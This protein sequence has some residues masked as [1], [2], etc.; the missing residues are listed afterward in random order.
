MLAGID[1]NV[2]VG[3]IKYQVSVLAHQ[4]ERLEPDAAADGGASASGAAGVDSSTVGVSARATQSRTVVGQSKKDREFRIGFGAGGRF[5]IADWLRIYFG[6]VEGTGKYGRSGEHQVSRTAMS[7]RRYN[8]ETQ[9]D[10][11][12]YVMVYELQVRPKPDPNGLAEIWLIG[13]NR[14]LA[15]DIAVP[16]P[17]VPVR[18]PSAA[19][20]QEAGTAERLGV[21][22]GDEALRPHWPDGAAGEDF[23]DFARGGASGLYPAFFVLPELAA[24]GAELHADL[25]GLPRSSDRLSWP[26]PFRQRTTPRNLAAAFGRLTAPQRYVI[27]LPEHNGWEQAMQLRARAYRP[28][29]LN[30]STDEVEV[31]QYSS[32]I[33]QLTVSRG[34][35]WGMGAAGSIF[36]LQ[37]N[38]GADA[39]HSEAGS[40][41]LGA[42]IN[43]RG[44]TGV[45]WERTRGRSDDEGSI[46]IRRETFRNG[47]VH[48]ARTDPVFEMTVMRWKDGE[49][50]QR[51]G[52][53]RFTD[54]LDLL[55]PARRWE[56][57]L[58]VPAAAFTPDP[59]PAPVA[60][61][62][63]DPPPAPGRFVSPALLPSSA[64]PE[65]MRA[66]AVLPA[67]TATLLEKKILQGKGNVVFPDLLWQ[68]LDAVYSSSSLETAY[69][70]L[71]SGPGLAVWLPVPRTSG[72]TLYLFVRVTG[73]TKATVSHRERPDVRLTLRG[74]SV[75]I[76]APTKSSSRTMFGGIDTRVQ[77]GRGA[78]YAGTETGWMSEHKKQ[79]S[80]ND[81][82]KTINIYRGNTKDGSDEFE[83]PMDFGIEMGVTSQMPEFV[84]ALGRWLKELPAFV[85]NLS[86]GGG[87][88]TSAQ[89]SGHSAWDW[90]EDN[91]P[92]V[93]G[94]VRLLVAHH[95]TQEA[96]LGRAPLWPAQ[97]PA[98]A[99]TPVWRPASRDEAAGKPPPSAVVLAEHIHPWTLN[100]V[101]AEVL[102]WA[103]LAAVHFGA[104][105]S[106][107]A[108]ASVQTPGLD[109]TAVDGLVYEHYT[110]PDKLLPKFEQLLS[111]SYRVPIGGQDV[112]VGLELTG[113]K[114]EGPEEG[115]LFK[116]KRYT[117]V[118]AGPKSESA[119][120]RAGKFIFGPEG[121]V[122][123]DGRSVLGRLPFQVYGWEDSD[124]IETGVGQTREQNQEATT[125]YLYYRL[126]ATVTMTGPQGV[127]RVPDVPLH[128]MLAHNEHDTVIAALEKDRKLRLATLFKAAAGAADAVA[129]KKAAEAAN[130]ARLDRLTAQAQ[131]YRAE[132]DKALRSRIRHQKQEHQRN[133]EA[134]ARLEKKLAL[135]S[136]ILNAYRELAR[137][138]QERASLLA[139]GEQ[140]LA[141]EPELAEARQE[142]EALD[143]HKRELKDQ[144]DKWAAT[145]RRRRQQRT[146]LR[147]WLSDFERVTRFP[148]PLPALRQEQREISDRLTALRQEKDARNAELAALR[149]QFDPQVSTAEVALDAPNE[150]G[151]AVRDRWGIRDFRSRAGAPGRTAAVACGGGA[152]SAAGAVG[153]AG[154][155]GG[156]VARIRSAVGQRR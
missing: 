105:P 129:A 46:Q 117:Q 126:T 110:G 52:Y 66:D 101:A 74:E 136:R 30:S 137:L 28:R 26:R 115:V 43:V 61:L 107:A 78:D 153:R 41:G 120:S 57:L 8:T 2:T 60:R 82:V 18:P 90:H 3:G 118:D 106:T 146:E 155:D 147:N 100:Q 96:P 91:L 99:G 154:A 141:R 111:A 89:Y 77:I 48:I 142:L 49:F 103:K 63:P 68:S 36:G 132:L 65:R 73:K 5:S 27:P 143:A 121:G 125:T 109:V 54:A 55:V 21:Y 7:Y 130:R 88:V 150:S 51:V 29:L 85:A 42:E 53:L 70:A 67:I 6:A 19:E 15:A 133:S 131:Q 14:E 62:T 32:A 148:D 138:Q 31:E 80:H 69:E 152:A 108:L 149:E 112:L 12:R 39:Q 20:L 124:K 23:L 86:R 144:V 119:T 116:T 104:A 127:I 93:G 139:E 94:S 98:P 135:G 113:G 25:N 10:T 71:S 11:H 45:D 17:F 128:A 156:A 95:L 13:E 84:S 92:P 102:R 1:I 22:G 134:I 33:A 123:I 4:L 38:M 64:F 140:L 44:V 114:R 34:Q 79:T 72:R 76:E 83:H 35:T 75:S 151:R 59:P 81:G 50:E 24:F 47:E 87:L 58:R 56:D 37:F 145:A 97:R 16:H 9:V 122:E 40:E